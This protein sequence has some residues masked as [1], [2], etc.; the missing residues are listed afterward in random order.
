MY[1]LSSSSMEKDIVCCSA[2]IPVS[3]FGLRMTQMNDSVA[4]D[5]ISLSIGIDS[6][7]DIVSTRSVVSK[8]TV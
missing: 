1:I 4:S 7:D 8:V 2:T 5:I 6:V 3:P